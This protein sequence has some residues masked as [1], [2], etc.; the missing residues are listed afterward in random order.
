MGLL[1]LQEVTRLDLGD[2]CHSSPPVLPKT[3]KHRRES[4]LENEGGLIIREKA[5]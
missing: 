5:V 3:G 2:F 1:Q 4:P